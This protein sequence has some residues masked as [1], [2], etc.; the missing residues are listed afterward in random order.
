MHVQTLTA[1]W[2][3]LKSHWLVKDAPEMGPVEPPYIVCN[4]IWRYTMKMDE[5]GW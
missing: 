5:A 3:K 2:K 1:K 4:D